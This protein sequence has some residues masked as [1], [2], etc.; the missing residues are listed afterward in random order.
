MVLRMAGLCCSLRAAAAAGHATAAAGQEE[1]GGGP[2]M[3]AW[4]PHASDAPLHEHQA[5][6]KAFRRHTTVALALAAHGGHSLHT[7]AAAPPWLALHALAPVRVVGN[8]RHSFFNKFEAK[9]DRTA[10]ARPQRLLL[11]GRAPRGGQARGLADDASASLFLKLGGAQETTGDR[12]GVVN[13]WVFWHVCSELGASRILPQP[14]AFAVGCSGQAIGAWW[15]RVEANVN[16][17]LAES[18]GR[19][20]PQNIHSQ[21]SASLWG[22]RKLPWTKAKWQV[23][24]FVC[25]QPPLTAAHGA[26][27]SVRSTC[28]CTCT[29]MVQPALSMARCARKPPCHTPVISEAM[30]MEHAR[31]QLQVCMHAWG[32]RGS[33]RW[34][35]QAGRRATWRKRHAGARS[36]RV[37]VFVRLLNAP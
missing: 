1:P 24:S 32:R 4:A 33:P 2:L 14:V 16:A 9:L 5:E 37:R 17:T 29:C 23:A 34:A 26:L 18:Q 31:T 36:R 30:L 7:A 25:P 3:T 8:Q 35:C 20:V 28:M 13:E 10:H 22:D 15:S 12:A 21:P 27:G 11:R 6:L 19:P